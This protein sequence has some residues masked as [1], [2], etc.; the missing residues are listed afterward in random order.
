MAR[1][2]A[3]DHAEDLDE[4]WRLER[5]RGLEGDA[6][7]AAGKASPAPVAETDVLIER[8]DIGAGIFTLVRAGSKIPAGLEGFGRQPAGSSRRHVEAGPP[9]VSGPRRTRRR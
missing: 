3:N 5:G 7:S 1:V 8:P 6:T 4:L 2:K 9:Q